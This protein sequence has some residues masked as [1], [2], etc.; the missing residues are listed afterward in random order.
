MLNYYQY[1]TH[2]HTKKTLQNEEAQ[3]IIDA[4]SIYKIYLVKL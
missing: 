4:T 3:N 1:L 2:T